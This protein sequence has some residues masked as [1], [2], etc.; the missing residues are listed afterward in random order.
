MWPQIFI[1]LLL[2]FRWAYLLYLIIIY[3]VANPK[4]VPLWDVVK[5]VVVIFQNAAVLEVCTFSQV[6]QTFSWGTEIWILGQVILGRPVKSPCMNQS[7]LCSI[8]T[9]VSR[10]VFGILFHVRR[11]LQT[12][13]SHWG[14]Q[15]ELY[16]L[17]AIHPTHLAVSLP[18]TFCCVSL[19]I[20]EP[21]CS[22]QPAVHTITSLCV[23]DLTR[24][25]HKSYTVFHVTQQDL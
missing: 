11:N 23:T 8:F 25:T 7:V 14:S 2:Y 5:P 15:P 16:V 10:S 18:I 6:H 24:P 20:S 4:K 19:S 17:L 3:Y 1:L 13:F 9:V 22:H 12:A 21:L